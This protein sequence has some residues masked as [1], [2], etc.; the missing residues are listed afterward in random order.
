[1]PSGHV[2]VVGGGGGGGGG[3][4]HGT[5]ASITDP[6]GQVWVGG[7]VAHADTPTASAKMTSFLMLSS[8][9][10]ADNETATI[11]FQPQI[12]SRPATR[13]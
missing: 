7:V 9:F 6:S 3:G 13:N 8:L 1:V 12:A 4:G 11:A 2:V 10:R 5:D